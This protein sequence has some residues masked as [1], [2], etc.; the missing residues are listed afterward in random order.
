MDLFKKCE[1]LDALEKVK[2]SGN[3]TY[4]SELTTGQDTQVVINGI[5]T[6]MIGSNNYLGL[7][8]HPEVIKAGQDALQ[9]YGSGCSGS[10]FLNGTLDIHRKLEDELAEF[11]HKEAVV[12]FSTGFQS[13]LAII[14]S[15]AG[16][17]DFILCDKENHA[18]IYDAC[19]LSYAKMIRYEHSDMQDLE[20]Q[21]A[22]IDTTYGGILIVT[23]GVFSMSGEICKLPEIVKLAKKYGAR[24]MVDDAHGL[25][26]LG[27]HGRGTAEHFGLENE[28]DIYMGTFSKSL[29]SLGGYMASTK[30]VVEYV[31]HTSRPFIF[32]ASI[33]PASVECARKSLEILK[34]ES[35]RVKNLAEISAYMRQLLKQNGVKIIESTTPIIPIFTYD[36]AKTFAACK[37]LMERGVYVNPVISPAVPVGSSLLRTSYTATHTKAQ[38]E[39]ACKQIAQ[40]LK[41]LD[42]I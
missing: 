17:N 32:S 2:A 15:I 34:R 41:Q 20:R 14:S 3:Y 42:C 25:G 36:D 6:V 30:E 21:L 33:T 22:K 37:M 35:Q 24:V 13:N 26:V 11:L 28:V 38:M 19:R 31:K 7:T 29:A 9:K 39:Y 1:R 10:R 12:T 27:E 40:V 8:S 16:R 4:F 23:D 5:D 18:S